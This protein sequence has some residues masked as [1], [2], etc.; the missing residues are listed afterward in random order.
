VPFLPFFALFLHALPLEAQQDALPLQAAAPLGQSLLDISLSLGAVLV[1]LFA[2]LWLLK[3]LTQP[4]GGQT[5]LRIRGATAVGPR[6][7][8]VLLDIGPRILV[9]GVTATQV[10]RLD[11]LTPEECAAPVPDSD[12]ALDPSHSAGTLA[13]PSSPLP[14]FAQRLSKALGDRYSSRKT[15]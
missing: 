10:T 1:I 13:P 6:E 5:R 12:S 2:C 11:A 9:L 4:R 7:R 3:K 15:P 8:V 14:G